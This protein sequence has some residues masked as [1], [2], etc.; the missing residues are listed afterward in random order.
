MLEVPNDAI[1]KANPR[2]PPMTKKEAVDN[3]VERDDLL[4]TVDMIADLPAD[5]TARTDDPHALGDY[6]S[7]SIDVL[8]HS[9]LRFVRLAHVVGRRRYDQLCAAVRNIPQEIQAV[10]TEKRN[11]VLPSVAG[12][13]SKDSHV[14]ENSTRSPK[15][16]SQVVQP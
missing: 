1:P 8:L 5:A 6:R 3:E 10:A 9:L 2:R 7:L 12:P 16:L 11:I 15:D 14:A 13:N 4:V